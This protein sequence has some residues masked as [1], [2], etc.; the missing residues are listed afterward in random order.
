MLIFIAISANK[1]Q[2]M[3]SIIN[4]GWKKKGLKINDRKTKAMGF[5][6]YAQKVRQR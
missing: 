3:L 1:L 2:M 5:E 6:K 4:D